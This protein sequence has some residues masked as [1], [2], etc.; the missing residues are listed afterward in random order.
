MP[1]FAFRGL[2]VL[3]R[4]RRASQLESQ[5][6]ILSSTHNLCPTRPHES[7]NSGSDKGDIKEQPEYLVAQTTS[8]MRGIELFAYK[9]SALAKRRLEL[10]ES[11]DSIPTYDSHGKPLNLVDTSTSLSPN[12]SPLKSV[13]R[14][15][16]MAMNRTMRLR[17]LE[18]INRRI[19]SAISSALSGASRKRQKLK[20]EDDEWLDVAAMI[21]EDT[22][23]PEGFRQLNEF[24]RLQPANGPCAKPYV[25]CDTYQLDKIIQSDLILHLDSLNL[26]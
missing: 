19:R 14:S 6:H 4:E 18:I 21:E 17:M 7:S 2:E 11:H 16:L 13:S 9:G 24:G 22:K 8:E 5:L 15:K 10:C 26:S 1:P 12:G 23:C 25:T 20:T 3:K